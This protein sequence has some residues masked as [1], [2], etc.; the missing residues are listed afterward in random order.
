MPTHAAILNSRSVLRLAGK[1]AR[2]WLQGLVTNDVESLKPG[3]GRYAALLTP[4]GKILF[5]FFV[6][7]DGEALL[8]DCRTDHAA[9]LSKRLAMYRL[10]ADVSVSEAGSALA[11]AVAWGEAPPAVSRAILYADPRD[12]CMGWR[13]VGEPQEFDLLGMESG[14]DDAYAAHR[15]ACG[16]P[17]GGVDFAYGDAFPHEANMDLLHGVDFKKGCYIGQEVV[18]RVQHRGT[19]RK[20]ILRVELAT[21]VPAGTPVM[22]GET[23]IGEIGSVNGRQAL[24]SLR[25]DRLADAQ[26]AG[27]RLSADG[28]ELAPL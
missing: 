6:L 25:T 17:E 15:I 3:E 24:A 14:H 28:V 5:D 23:V 22:A 16:M 26:A 4:Q 7:V 11:V 8:I 10:R 9:S 27:S 2:N 18:S 19:A 13:F 12:P 1:D 21:P 20:R